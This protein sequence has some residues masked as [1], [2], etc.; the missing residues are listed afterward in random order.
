MDSGGSLQ[1]FTQMEEHYSETIKQLMM[2]A[3][4]DGILVDKYELLDNAYRASG[5]FEDG[6]YLI[7]YPSE[8]VEKYL[9]RK[10]MAY[11]INY[12]NQ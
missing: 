2:T 12:V 11:Y 9:R 6:S 5:G 10:H 4:Y 3:G 7:P 8:R 1:E